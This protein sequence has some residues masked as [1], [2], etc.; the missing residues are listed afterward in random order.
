MNNAKPRGTYGGNCATPDCPN[1]TRWIPVTRH[2]SGLYYCAKCCDRIAEEDAPPSPSAFKVE[3][4]ES[5]S[6]SIRVMLDRWS[7]PE[8]PRQFCDYG[9]CDHAPT[10]VVMRSTGFMTELR[11]M[12]VDHAGESTRG[13]EYWSMPL[14]TDGGVSNV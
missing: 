3:F 5:S 10:A 12:C 7:D 2:R 6:S 13:G 1:A 4:S 11:L 14:L 8:A 9:N